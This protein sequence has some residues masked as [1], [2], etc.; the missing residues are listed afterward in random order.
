MGSG[1]VSRL[2]SQPWQRYAGPVTARWRPSGYTSSG[3]CSDCGL[4]KGRCF[5][6]HWTGPVPYF[7]VSIES[8]LPADRYCQRTGS[9]CFFLL[10]AGRYGQRGIHPGLRC[11]HRPGSEAGRSPGDPGRDFYRGTD[12]PGNRQG[13][14]LSDSTKYNCG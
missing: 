4:S 14:Y 1:G 9:T 5:C 6:W 10:Q 11:M 8:M 2:S 13:Q 12:S 7:P 3:G